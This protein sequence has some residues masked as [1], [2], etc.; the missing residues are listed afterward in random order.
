MGMRLQGNPYDLKLDVIMMKS[1][2]R[3]WFCWKREKSMGMVGWEK[4]K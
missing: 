1:G 2:R 3:N 4:N